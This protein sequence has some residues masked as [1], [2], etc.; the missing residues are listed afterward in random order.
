MTTPRH[1]SDFEQL[2]AGSRWVQGLARGL[3]RD[4]AGAEDVVQDAWVVAL[5]RRE[6]VRE[7]RAWLSGVVRRLTLRQG[8]TDERR[9]R[10]EQLAAR[11]ERVPSVAELVERSELQERLSGAVRALAEPY[12]ATVLLRYVEGLSAERIA[13]IQGVPA[14]T[15]RTRLARALELLRERLDREHG[16]RSS[17]IAILLPL[18]DLQ[19]P[20][21]GALATGSTFGSIAMGTKSALVAAAAALAVAWFVASYESS[22]DH[23]VAVAPDPEASIED[24][25]TTVLESVPV[26]AARVKVAV[27]PLEVRPSDP[28]VGARRASIS[29]YVLDAYG[30]PLPTGAG[31]SVHVVDAFGEGR[32]VRTEADGAYTTGELTTGRWWLLAQAPGWQRQERDLDLQGDAPDLRVDFALAPRPAVDVRLLAPDGRTF[33][34]AAREIGL[35]ASG[36]EMVAVATLEPPGA[37]FEEV[38]GSLNNPFGVGAM[39]WNGQV[40]ISLPS[41]FWC[42]VLLDVEPPLS[43]S[44]VHYHDVLHSERIEPEKSELTVTLDPTAVAARLGGVEFTLVDGAT[45]AALADAHVML[46]GKGSVGPSVATD[47]Q[48]R[49]RVEGQPAGLYDLGIA[50]PGMAVVSREVDVPVGRVADLGT[51]EMVPAVPIR[52]RAVDEDGNAVEVEIR[53]CAVPAPGDLPQPSGDQARGRPDGTFEISGL[54]P[55]R[56]LLQFKDRKLGRLQGNAAELMAPNLIVDTRSGPVEDL[57]VRLQKVAYVVTRWDGEEFAQRR[58]RFFDGDGLLRQRAG[59]FSRG[60]TR[61]ALIPGSWRVVAVDERG[62]AVCERSFELG[63]EPLRI[64][65]TPGD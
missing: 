19:H 16:G 40:G 55:G 63:T 26:D 64:E 24:P 36:M 51:F 3:L 17:W 52:G 18:A 12:R 31:A 22:G 11:P 43:V 44:V 38:L 41:D 62:A 30:R 34:D 50:F 15:V 59:F 28:G 48:G 47:A 56:W 2:L 46:H 5:S 45:G 61:V 57:L 1:E 49:A 39:W 9:R 27:E 54:P 6:P 53:S 7:P 8:R 14:S 20:A 13:A 23:A 42:R 65:L 60:P 21:H 33:W 35:A 4:H 29:G 58:L 32:T 37:R 10:R 25:T